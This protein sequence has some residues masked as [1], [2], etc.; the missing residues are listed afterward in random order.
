MS[1]YDS[2]NFSTLVQDGQEIVVHSPPSDSWANIVLNNVPLDYTCFLAYKDD[3]IKSFIVLSDPSALADDTYSSRD[4]IMINPRKISSDISISTKGT[5]TSQGEKFYRER[6]I[7][8]TKQKTYTTKPFDNS[9]LEKLNNRV[10]IFNSSLEGTEVSFGGDGNYEI[11]DKY[12][13]TSI[14]HNW[15][16]Y[17][18][19]W[20]LK[21]T[22]DGMHGISLIIPS[23]PLSVT[24]KDKDGKEFRKSKHS[25]MWEDKNGATFWRFKILSSNKE[26]MVS[27]GCAY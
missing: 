17:R 8:Q 18:E 13:N 14:I 27:G 16:H 9:K 25:I 20:F 23:D 3:L 6:K 24:W 2:D 22:D 15:F 26:F 19:Y 4:T 10:K 21:N 1:S 12:L 7:P 11:S 5:D